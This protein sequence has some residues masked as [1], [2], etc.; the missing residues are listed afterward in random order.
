MPESPAKLK[1]AEKTKDELADQMRDVKIS[2]MG[3]TDKEESLRLYNELLAQFPSC[4]SIYTTRISALESQLK[5]T[6]EAESL[7]EIQREIKDLIEKVSTGID[8]NEL[9]LYFGQKNPNPDLKLKAQMEKNRN[10]FVDA[11]VKKGLLFPEDVRE[12]WTEAT[13]FFEPGDSRVSLS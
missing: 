2:W 13:A 4:L 7:A 11:V 12:A 1:P 8:K 10:A 9:L 6:I 3:K 5:D